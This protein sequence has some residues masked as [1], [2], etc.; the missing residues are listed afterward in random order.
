MEEKRT[1]VI[2]SDERDGEIF[3]R[4]LL[5][6]AQ[7]RLLRWMIEKEYANSG[8]FFQILDDDAQP[9]TI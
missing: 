3:D 5:T 7:L 1:M 9:I 2:I 6:D 8:I 4:I